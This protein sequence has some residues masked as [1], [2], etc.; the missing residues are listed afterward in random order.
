MT[1]ALPV[2]P[3][4]RAVIVDI[5]RGFA[6]V[7]VLIAN[8]TSYINQN[9]PSDLLYSISSPLDKA[10]S[11]INTI[12]FEWKFMTIF[13]ILF[14]YG[15]GLI[16]ISM[17]KKNINP[18]SFFIRR[19]FW[20]FIMGLVHALFWWGDVLHLYAASGVFLL[21]FR[22]LS[23]KAIL[24][25]SLLFMFVIPPFVSFLFQDQPDYFT[26]Q[27]LRLLYEQ[28]R[29]G[30]I[31]DVFKANISLYYKAFIL[32]GGDIHDIIE[33]LGRFLFGYFLLQVRLF[34]SIKA[35][36]QI[37]KKVLLITFPVMTAYLTASWIA[38]QG[39]IDTDEIY[40]EPLIKVGI[41]STSCF[42]V[43]MVVLLFIKYEQSKIFLA[44][45][46]LGK[47]TL[48]NYLLISFL[49]ITV[50]YGIGLGQLGTLPMHIMW[51]CAFA[52]LIAEITFSTY[53]LRKFK[54]GPAE[55]IWRE[56]IYQKRISLRE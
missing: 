5:V 46:A 17:E 42:Y 29:Y 28:F 19:M 20:L 7:G 18:N 56:L 34:E 25:S 30:N 40:W 13:S 44:L 3:N 35:K 41:I 23:V 14:G 52:W 16:L 54:Y 26:N 38:V 48:T 4:E 45:Q 6:L 1:T 33:T 22:K 31:L 24:I 37:F 15:F 50:L 10:L 11:N 36:T 47:M 12:F 55:W 9:V 51:L 39:L 32:T 8:F 27:N 2:Q 21:M 49:C 43:S 53:W